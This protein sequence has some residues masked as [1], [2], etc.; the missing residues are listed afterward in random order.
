MAAVRKLNIGCGVI[1]PEGWHNVDNVD[2]GQQWI[3]D[4]RT[5]RG[6]DWGSF[7]LIVANHLLSCFDHHELQDTVLPILRDTLAPGGVLRIL[8]PDANKAILAYQMGDHAFFPQ[9]NDMTVIDERFCTFLTWFGESKSIFT[10]QYLH[11]LLYG[12]GF[13]VSPSLFCGEEPV[14]VGSSVLD[15][16]CHEALIVEAT[17]RD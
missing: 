12:A 14:L 6:A 9:G 10:Y 2:Y 8:V 11:D 13:S 4:V 15:D 7:D 16:R 17:P 1:Q 5:W 3:S